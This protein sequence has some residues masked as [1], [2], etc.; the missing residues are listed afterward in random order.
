MNGLHLYMRYVGISVRSQM[1]YHASLVLLSVGS[2]LSGAIEILAIW[3]LFERFKTLRS[4]RLPEIALFFG[5]IRT[6]IAIGDAF[7]RGFDVFGRLIRSGQFDRILLRPRSAALQVVGTELT[8]HRAGKFLQGLIVLI[9]A[10][11]ALEIGWTFATVCLVV[12]S[13]L[14]GACFFIGLWVLQATMAFWTV[15]T[16]EIMN[17]LTYG[18][19]E[20]AQYPLSIYR[21]WFRR[22]FTFVVPLACVSYYPAM[23]ILD[24]QSQVLPGWS[25]F[26]WASPCVG[27]AFLFGCLQIWRFGVWHYRSTGS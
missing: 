16:L 13:V 26:A 6:A 22:F 12:A 3:A 15:E 5:L 27:L 17:A 14:G 19:C 23:C 10:S 20:T 24:R 11:H 4:W 7:G 1:Q 9:W 21:R 2:F 25:W 8:V 18:G